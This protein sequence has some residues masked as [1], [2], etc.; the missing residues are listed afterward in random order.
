[1]VVVCRER[2]R[3]ERGNAPAGA[4]VKV[5]E[6]AEGMVRPKVIR[7]DEKNGSRSIAFPR[8]QHRHRHKHG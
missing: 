5:G 6:S 1:M 8:H 7:G 3:V 2:A 4:A